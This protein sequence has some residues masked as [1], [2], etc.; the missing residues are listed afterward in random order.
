LRFLALSGVCSLGLQVRK[1]DIKTDYCTYRAG[2]VT[3]KQK[4]RESLD[5]EG[6]YLEGS[7]SK[8]I[9]AIQLT[10][11]SERRFGI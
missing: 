8:K 6:F 3:W 7:I 9:I 11:F 2:Q 1:G 4:I 5:F 10:K